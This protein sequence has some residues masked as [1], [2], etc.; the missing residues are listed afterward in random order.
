MQARTIEESN[1]NR[2]HKKS[3]LYRIIM[4]DNTKE[5][6]QA[7]PLLVNFKKHQ[8]EPKKERKQK[9]GHILT[10]ECYSIN[11]DFFTN[12]CVLTDANKFVQKAKGKW[13]SSSSSSSSFATNI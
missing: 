2:N 11:L 13:L 3:R 1:K 9:F 10:K 4:L 7:K 6:L 12:V 8:N 5:Y